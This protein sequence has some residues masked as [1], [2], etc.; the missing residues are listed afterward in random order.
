MTEHFTGL[1]VGG[2]HDGQMLDHWKPR[3]LMLKP[4]VNFP[5]TGKSKVE[6]KEMGVYVHFGDT[7]KWTEAVE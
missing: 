6:A 7:W 1:C 3:K 5:V 4:M 2:T